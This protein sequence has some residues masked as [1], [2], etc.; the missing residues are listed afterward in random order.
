M[1]YNVASSCTI[2]VVDM[3]M[4][5]FLRFGCKSVSLHG[6]AHLESAL[7]RPGRSP[8]GIITGQSSNASQTSLN[9][10]HH[11]DDDARC[12]VSN[13]NAFGDD[14]LVWAA[15]PKSLSFDKRS[16]ACHVKRRHRWV[17]GM[18]L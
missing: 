3:A 6:L 4:R 9:D 7:H 5:L 18:V 11:A 15:L 16:E 17:L 13:H 12:A 10:D 8:R 1:A 2:S 14:P